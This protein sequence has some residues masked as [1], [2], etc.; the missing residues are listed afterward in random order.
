[1]PYKVIFHTGQTVDLKTKVESGRLSIENGQLKITGK[2]QFQI[3]LETAHTVKMFRLHGLGRMIK[4]VH[5]DLRV[6]LN[7]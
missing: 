6:L 7:D 5:N 3:Q 4:L 1:M 2:S